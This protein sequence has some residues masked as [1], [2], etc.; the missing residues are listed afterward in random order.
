VSKGELKRIGYIGDQEPGD[1]P[2]GA[3]FETHIEQGPVLEDADKTIGVVQG[4][5]G[6]RWFDCTVTGMEAHAGPTP[7]ALRKDAMQVSTRIMQEVVAAAQ[8][9]TSRMAA[10]RWAWCRCFPTAAT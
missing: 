9:A 8:C 3:Y 10:A 5:L 4:V 1:H 7:M 2:I 6:I